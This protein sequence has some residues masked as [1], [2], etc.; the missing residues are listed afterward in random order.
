MW[1]AKSHLIRRQL[2]AI[3]RP[4]SETVLPPREHEQTSDV[5]RIVF[6]QQ[7]SDVRIVAFDN[8]TAND[9]KDQSSLVKSADSLS[10]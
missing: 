4:S 10:T 8:N 1:L 9:N 3:G 7:S 2:D 5:D 6:P